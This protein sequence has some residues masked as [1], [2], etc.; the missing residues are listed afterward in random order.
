M[1]IP[2]N[3]SMEDAKVRF[4]IIRDELPLS[5]DNST[6]SPGASN[7]IWIGESTVLRVCWRGNTERLSIEA[8]LG[9]ELPAAVRYP[10]TVA[11]GR[12]DSL[13]WQVQAKI[14]AVSLDKTFSS[15]SKE[16]LQRMVSQLAGI[17]RSLHEWDVPQSVR[18]LLQSKSA[19][20]RDNPKTQLVL[21]PIEF[22]YTVLE[23]IQGLRWF[24]EDLYVTTLRR[25]DDL[26]QLD[27]FLSQTE[28]ISMIHCDASPSN[29]LERGG[30]VV[31]LLDF[32]WARLGP[33]DMELLI[34]L[35]MA[36]FA[37]STSNP[38]PPIFQWLKKDYPELFAAPNSR[39]RL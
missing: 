10:R 23:E 37:D 26:S 24:P 38:F 31:S 14:D 32:E 15:H 34:W 22:G 5:F 3:D 21:L 1:D 28:A 16:S 25:L 27:P 20:Q 4:Q 6:F 29:I 13:V 35:H 7:D 12:K 17:Y 18:L 19:M 39:E 30:Q 8:Q 33:I 2:N 36:R 11:W 9:S